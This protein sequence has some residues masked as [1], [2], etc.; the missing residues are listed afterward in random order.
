MATNEPAIQ[1][2]FLRVLSGLEH[3]IQ[4]TG[5]R[6]AVIGGVAVVLNGYLRNT[7]DVDAIVEIDFTHLENFISTAS[8]FGFEAR[9]PDAVEFARRYYVL[10]LRHL[11]TLL[12]VDLSLALTPFEREAISRGRTADLEGVSITVLVPEDLLIMKSVAQRPI[13]LIDVV[14]LYKLH[15]QQIDLK[16]VRYW[17]EEF[18]EALDEP[19]LW[20]RVESLLRS[21]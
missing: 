13:D 3:L 10:Q 8:S 14:E 21:D 5:G 15:S 20:S 19:D 11:P 9:I 17:V 6:L 2:E 4:A 18:G 16:R 1:P 12:P 7:V